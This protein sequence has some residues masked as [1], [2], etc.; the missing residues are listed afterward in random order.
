MKRYFLTI[1]PRNE[2]EL[3]LQY[4]EIKEVCPN[5]KCGYKL[6]KC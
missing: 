4:G 1:D 2:P 5:M 6:Y 3:I